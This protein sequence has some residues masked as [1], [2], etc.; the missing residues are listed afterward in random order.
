VAGR[1]PTRP[2]GPATGAF[3]Q[4][5]SNRPEQPGSRTQESPEFSRFEREVARLREGLA[6]LDRIEGSY[7]AGDNSA[8][9]VA[10]VGDT[11]PVVVAEQWDLG[12][13]GAGE[14]VFHF[15]SDDL[16]RY[17]SRTRLLS[18]AGAPS[19]GWYERAMTIYFERGRFAGGTGSIDGRVAE[20][21]EH[22]V[23]GAWRQAEP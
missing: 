11:G 2:S 20:P 1:S 14:A 23:R 6:A 22:E 10:F 13:Y 3:G 15:R 17:R 4:A 5:E 19:D 8:T 12:E 7:T 9:W 18:N 16:V 21:D